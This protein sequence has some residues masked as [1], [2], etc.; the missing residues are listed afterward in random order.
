MFHSECFQYGKLSLCCLNNGWMQ[1]ETSNL[2]ARLYRI[3]TPDQH[4][5]YHNIIL[6]DD[7]L[8]KQEDDPYCFGATVGPVAGRI[9]NAQ[10]QGYHLEK[11]QGQHCLHS[12]SHGFQNQYFTCLGVQETSDYIEVSYQ[13]DPLVITGLPSVDTIVRYRLTKNNELHIIYEGY[14]HED[15]LFNPTNHAYFNLS[16]Q[17]QS[18]RD[19]QLY[20]N[21]TYRTQLDDMCL[22]TGNILPVA[23]TEYDFTTL[24]LLKDRV[25]QGLDD[26]FILNNDMQKKVSLALQHPT[27][28]RKMTIVTERDSIIVFTGT[29]MTDETRLVHGGALISEEGL[30]IECQEV[31]DACHNQLS[32]SQINAG[33]TKKYTTVYQ[34]SVM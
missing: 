19:H 28:G 26:C 11:N 14:A 33:E 6:N 31:P 34:F 32:N 1:I 8:L 17:K 2:G 7:D 15:S 4:G 27:S 29:N 20:I 9:A 13:N 25:P 24:S 10:W 30:A 18:I 21:A 16:G 23:E 3:Y 22:P 5:D 12:G